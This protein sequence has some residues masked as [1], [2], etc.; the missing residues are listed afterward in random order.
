VACQVK[1]ISSTAIQ[2]PV[3][4]SIHCM[5]TVR[6]VCK[7]CTHGY[8]CLS[9]PLHNSTTDITI[10][11]DISLHPGP[12]GIHLNKNELHRL[13]HDQHSQQRSTA[14]SYSRK[15]L[16]KIRRLTCRLYHPS[17]DHCFYV[18]LAGLFSFHGSKGAQNRIG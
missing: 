11:G 18:K 4:S 1:F 8:I 9:L 14:I 6:P 10:Y 7:W 13:L 17:S 16:L 5:Q 3:T 2:G 15:E 12:R